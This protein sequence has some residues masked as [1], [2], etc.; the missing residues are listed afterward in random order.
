MYD[1]FLFLN[2]IDVLKFRLKNHSPFVKKFV[3]LESNTTF[4]GQERELQF[5]KQKK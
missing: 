3:I 1:C 2:E 5:Q 4:T